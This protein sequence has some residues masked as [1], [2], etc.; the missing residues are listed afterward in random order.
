MV[1]VAQVAVGVLTKSRTSERYAALQAT[2]LPHFGQV[3]VFESHT[4]MARAQQ[5]W[6]YIPQRLYTRFPHAAYYLIVDDDVFI[7]RARLYE[8]LAHRDQTELALYGPGFCDWGVKHR[9]AWP[10]DLLISS[11]LL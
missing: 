5:V 6:K 1:L 3:L 2:W 4:E 7:S 8:Y 9:Y 11:D 10:S